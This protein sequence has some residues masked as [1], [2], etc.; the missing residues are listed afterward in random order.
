MNLISRK[1]QYVSRRENIPALQKRTSQQT[2]QNFPYLEIVTDWLKYSAHLKK[3]KANR[4]A[5]QGSRDI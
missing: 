3:K 2:L 4:P 5:V 1:T